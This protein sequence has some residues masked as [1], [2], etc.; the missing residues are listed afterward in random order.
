MVQAQNARKI[1]T[2]LERKQLRKDM[3][4][5]EI[6]RASR[7]QGV[8][9]I[10]GGLEELRCRGA[11][12]GPS[13]LVAK[14]E[15]MCASSPREEPGLSVDTTAGAQEGRRVPWG[16]GVRGARVGRVCVVGLGRVRIGR[17]GV[18]EY[19]IAEF[20]GDGAVEGALVLG[21]GCAWVEL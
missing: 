1:I 20:G 10:Q 14:I 12:G 4:V 19:A 17:E 3:N 21:G 18:G 16:R 7:V 2:G 13:L 8:Q 15:R 6:D 9:R 5:A 11:V